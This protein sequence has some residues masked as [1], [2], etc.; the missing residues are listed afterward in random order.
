M[1]NIFIFTVSHAV[2]VEK[3]FTSLFHIFVLYE[4]LTESVDIVLFIDWIILIFVQVF[5][6]CTYYC[7]IGFYFTY[8]SIQILPRL[9][10]SSDYLYYVS[11]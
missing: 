3:Y 1:H 6:S 2:P 5:F 8:L 7:C 11:V 10:Q 9:L 4:K